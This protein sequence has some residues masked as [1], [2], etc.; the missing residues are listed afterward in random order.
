MP[1]CTLP[2]PFGGRRPAAGGWERDP[3][4]KPKAPGWLLSLAL[5]GGGVSRG[6]RASPGSRGVGKSTLG[7]SEGAFLAFPGRTF[8]SPRSVPSLSPGVGM[9]RPTPAFPPLLPSGA[10]AL[11]PS[12]HVR[13]RKK[14]NPGFGGPGQGDPPAVDSE[15]YPVLLP[16][17]LGRGILRHAE[18]GPVPV[19][20]GE[21]GRAGRPLPPRGGRYHP[22]REERAR[23]RLGSCTAWGRGAE[24]AG[25]LP[26]AGRGGAGQRGRSVGRT[27]PP[28][29]GGEV[30][31][32]ARPWRGEGAGV[33]IGL[34]EAWGR[35]LVRRLGRPPFRRRRRRRP[36]HVVQLHQHH[37]GGGGAAQR[38]QDQDQEEA[39]RVPESEAIPGQRADP[40]RSDVGGEP[41]GNQLPRARPS[42]RGP[43]RAHASPTRPQP[44][45]ALAWPAL[46]VTRAPPRQATCTPTPPLHA[47]PA[48]CA[49]LHATRG[50]VPPTVVCRRVLPF[51]P[52]PQ[53]SCVW[54]RAAPGAQR[55]GLGGVEW[56][57]S[58]PL[59]S[60]RL[61]HLFS[62]FFLIIGCLAHCPVDRAGGIGLPE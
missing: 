58:S 45:R 31:G 1:A 35:W 33:G 62:P 59:T 24:R 48:G 61:L 30:T 23:W 19:R 7:W 12:W 13:L 11:P 27:E 47:I 43:V 39:F 37:G 5:G 52:A 9:V 55:E 2:R 42:E 8:F 10:V 36:G 32:R 14:P 46:P 34:G 57:S 3:F 40:Q 28:G 50:L 29:R 16:S 15:T 54:Q 44:P 53:A 49:S 21:E 17:L 56:L 25:G 20:P 26:G 41:H 18:A 51:P 60:P 38:Q 6:W 22:G 4:I